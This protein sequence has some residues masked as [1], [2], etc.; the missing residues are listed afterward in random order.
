M[1]PHDPH[2]TYLARTDFRGTH[3]LVGL[4]PADRN[5]HIYVLGKTGTGKSTLLESLM[6]QDLAHG[7]GFAVLDPH[8]DLVERVL[9]AVPPGSPPITHIYERSRRRPANGLQPTRIRPA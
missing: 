1:T 6:R 5:A 9:A 4:T 3:K 7:E 8:G 2:L